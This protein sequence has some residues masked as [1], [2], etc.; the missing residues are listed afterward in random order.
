MDKTKQVQ[1][2]EKLEIVEELI[3]KVYNTMYPE[4]DHEARL[5]WMTKKEN[6]FSL[7]DKFPKCI[8]LVNIGRQFLFPTCNRQGITDPRVVKF[9]LDLARKLSEK[10]KDWVDGDKLNL[11]IQ[12][13]ERLERKYSQ[14]IV[15]PSDMAAKKA[16]STKI[17]NKINSYIKDLRQI[18]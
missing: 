4:E 1:L 10:G 9:S 17:I 15:K 16:N 14:D 5:R 6:L 12:K 2:E 3:R 11:A 13:L 7:Y 8:Y 18:G